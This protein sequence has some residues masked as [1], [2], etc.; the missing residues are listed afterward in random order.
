MA[1]A[2]SARPRDP[3]RQAIDAEFLVAA[4]QILDVG[5][6]G[7]RGIDQLAWSA[8]SGSWWR[9]SAPLPPTTSSPRWWRR[10]TAPRLRRFLWPGMDTK[11][12][13]VASHSLPIFATVDRRVDRHTLGSGHYIIEEGLFIRNPRASLSRSRKRAP[14]GKVSGGIT[15]RT[16]SGLNSGLY[17]RRFSRIDPLPFQKDPYWITYP[18]SGRRAIVPP[19]FI[20]QEATRRGWLVRR[21]R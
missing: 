2:R 11:H 6:R 1:G 16:A 8:T 4:A 18:E 12:S 19:G 3:C 7:V 21:D 10:V 20:K 9:P 17:L 15:N 5:T 13:S 14:S